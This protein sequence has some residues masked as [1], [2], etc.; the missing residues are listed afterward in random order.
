MIA[1]LKLI[2]LRYDGHGSHN[3]MGFGGGIYHSADCNNYYMMYM[4]NLNRCYD[5]HN[6]R[7]HLYDV[8]QLYIDIIMEIKIE[9]MHI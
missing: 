1:P 4:F 5:I 3:G 7:H 8:P 9:D 2:S 6:Y